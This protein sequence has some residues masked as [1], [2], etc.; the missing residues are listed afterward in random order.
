MPFTGGKCAATG[1]CAEKQHTESRLKSCSL[2][3]WLVLLSGCTCV[4]AVDVV[5]LR[6]PHICWNCTL[7]SAKV[8]MMTA[9][10]TFCKTERWMT[11]FRCISWLSLHCPWHDINYLTGQWTLGLRVTNLDEPGQ[12][13]NESYKVEVGAPSRETVDGSVH[14]EHP[15]LLWCSL[16]HGE[17]TCT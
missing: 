10:K 9:M 6:D 7:I 17:D 13:E 8:S 16:V 5:L 3:R 1:R 12:E 4:V 11:M 2:H 15:A 14:E